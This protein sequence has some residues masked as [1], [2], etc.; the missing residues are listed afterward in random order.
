MPGLEAFQAWNAGEESVHLRRFHSDEV[1]VV[2]FIAECASKFDSKFE[3]RSTGIARIGWKTY[4]DR[5]CGHS[6]SELVGTAFRRLCTEKVPF[7]CT[8][9]PKW[10]AQPRTQPQ[11]AVFVSKVVIT[12]GTLFEIVSSFR[13]NYFG[14]VCFLE[15][16]STQSYSL[17]VWCVDRSLNLPERF[18]RLPEQFFQFPE[19]FVQ[20]SEQTVQA[21]WKTVQ[22]KGK[23]EEVLKLKGLIMLLRDCRFVV[24]LVIK[25]C[26][27][28]AD[29]N[30]S[31]GILPLLL[32]TFIIN[33]QNSGPF[34]CLNKFSNC[35]N[36][37][38][39]CLNNFSSYLNNLFM[40]YL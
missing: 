14:Y 21:I 27:L 17:R 29:M 2:F 22:R 10:R 23:K 3:S 31:S 38:F 6:I 40:R 28:Y 15:V 30:Q 4:C 37:S 1:M 18:V 19:R 25:F 8:Q 11:I 32:A 26:R 20:L 35:L 33:R 24:Q 7:C 34:S 16:V 39:S 36:N 5:G 12:K 9:P 13:R